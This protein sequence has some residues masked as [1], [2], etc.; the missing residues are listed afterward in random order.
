MFQEMELSSPITKRF[1]EVTFRA[2][3]KQKPT[4]KKF[5]TFQEM[6]LSN[7]KL[8]KFLIFFLKTF[9]EGTCEAWKIKI[10]CIFSKK[11]VYLIF[12]IRIFFIKIFSF[13]IRNFCVVSNKRRR[14]FFFNNIFILIACYYHVTCKFQ[15]KSI[16]YSFPEYQET[17]CSKQAPYQASLSVSAPYR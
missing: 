5:L 3:K 7:P 10:S 12:F 13:R 2:R 15:N 6:E 16:L 17:P 14:L 11:F 4:L 1:R 8:K 9:L